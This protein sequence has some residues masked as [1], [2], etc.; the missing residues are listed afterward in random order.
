MRGGNEG[1]VMGTEDKEAGL[2]GLGDIQGDRGVGTVAAAVL[3]LEI[4]RKVMDERPLA[5]WKD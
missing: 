1:G 5:A 2:S 3:M 4:I